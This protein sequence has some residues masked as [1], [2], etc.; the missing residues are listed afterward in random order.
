[1]TDPAIRAEAAHQA[2]REGRP[3][4]AS[5]VWPYL[6]HRDMATVMRA[7]CCGDCALM[8]R[9]RP[10]RSAPIRLAPQRRATHRSATQRLRKGM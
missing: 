2:R 10:I 8:R 7:E 4:A 1:M 9:Y 5:E 6:G 3:A